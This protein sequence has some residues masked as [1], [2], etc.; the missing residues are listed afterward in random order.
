MGTRSMI[1]LFTGQGDFVKKIL[2]EDGA[3]GQ[4][5]S[6]QWASTWT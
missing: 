3:M 6:A 5:D 2:L 4:C 1:A